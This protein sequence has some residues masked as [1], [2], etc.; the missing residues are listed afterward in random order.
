[1][2]RR[3]QTGIR[4]ID[5]DN[6]PTRLKNAR[7]T[8][9]FIHE[10][11]ECVGADDFG[12]DGPLAWCTTQVIQL[13]MKHSGLKVF[14]YDAWAR[15]MALQDGPKKGDRVLITGDGPV[16]LLEDTSAKRCRGACER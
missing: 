7:D 1:M 6:P 14:F 12:D 11:H 10:L 8:V 15:Q 9:R 16:M 3:T 2:P 5:P 4:D 13:E